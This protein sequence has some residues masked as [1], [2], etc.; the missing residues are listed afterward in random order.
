MDIE[1]IIYFNT[2]QWPVVYF[3]S[4][5]VQINDENFDEYKKSYLQLLVR[6][7]RNNEKMILICD[8]NSFNNDN[9]ALPIKYFIKQ[10]NFNK[11]M[12]E[13]NKKYLKCVCILCKNKNIKTMLNLYFSISKPA[14]PYKL[15]RSMDKANLFVCEKGEI[16]FDIS[17]F[18]MNND[19]NDIN[20]I[21]DCDSDE[22]IVNDSN[23]ED[24]EKSLT[25]KI[26][27]FDLTSD[28]YFP[29]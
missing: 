13:Y 7:K 10:S 11:E 18:L 9:E 23:D 25:K 20:D 6:C 15:C 17:I 2:E 4:G 29:S 27:K 28:L 12:Y 22:V 26:N 19:I 21:N 1:N 8:L 5:N 3:K 14:S 16:K 24:D